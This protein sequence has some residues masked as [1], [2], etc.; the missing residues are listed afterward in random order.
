MGPLF[1]QYRCIKC[2]RDEW[3]ELP[4]TSYVYVPTCCNRAMQKTGNPF[5]ERHSAAH[6]EDSKK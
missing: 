5:I 1:E 3:I 2:G 6:G 4:Q